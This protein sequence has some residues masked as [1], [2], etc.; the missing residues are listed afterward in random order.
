MRD[1]AQANLTIWWTMNPMYQPID[2][3]ISRLTK[4]PTSLLDS[5]GTATST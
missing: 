2:L 5:M 1:T 4:L 3:R